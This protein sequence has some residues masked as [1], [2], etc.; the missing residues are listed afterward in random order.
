MASTS[1]TNHLQVLLQ[2][3]EE[4]NQAH[5]RLRTGLRGRQYGLGSLNRAI[6]VLCVSSWEA[7]I[8]QLLIES[9]DLMRPSNPVGSPWPTVKAFAGSQIARF[10]TPNS[11]N[12]K[13][14]FA[15]CLGLPDITAHWSWRGSSVQNTRIS[16]NDILML[17]HHVAHGVNP[18]P[19]IHNGYASWM[20]NFFRRLGSCS[21]KGVQQHLVD[22]G[23]VVPW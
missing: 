7:F 14:L 13:R 15:E 1:F 23:V 5:R 9:L 16:L 3:P 21:E 8:E 10:N 17:R 11:E 19:K 12:T 4:M 18:R 6:V 22:L 2:D 20:P